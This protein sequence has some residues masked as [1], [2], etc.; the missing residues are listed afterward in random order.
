MIPAPWTP[1]LLAL[2][3]SPTHFCTC[4]SC[5]N[6]LDEVLAVD[7]TRSV[8]GHSV[9]SGKPE[10]LCP[11]CAATCGYCNRR[12]AVVSAANDLGWVHHVC[13]ECHENHWLAPE[14]ARAS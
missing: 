5:G 4:D 12:P 1:Q 14:I 7:G 2:A 8:N 3:Y 11:E 6:D 10:F 13:S 9:R